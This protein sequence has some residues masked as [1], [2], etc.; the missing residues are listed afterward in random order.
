MTPTEIVQY[1]I[2]KLNQLR[3][4]ADVAAMLL[5]R[6]VRGWRNGAGCDP[7]SVWLT[8]VLTADA[9]ESGRRPERAEL[10]A[11]NTTLEVWDADCMDVSLVEIAPGSPV[12]RFNEGFSAGLFGDLVGSPDHPAQIGG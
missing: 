3:S 1:E 6:G 7:L 10:L 12:H 8:L 9:E 5:S 11:D 4:A 2:A